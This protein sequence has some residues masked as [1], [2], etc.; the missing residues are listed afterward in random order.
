M[1]IQ[2]ILAHQITQVLQIES[3]T[4]IKMVW[5][6]KCML[7]IIIPVM[8]SNSNH[9]G[10]HSAVGKVPG[11]RCESDSRVQI[12]GSQVRSRPGPMLSWR[13]VMK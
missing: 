5:Y 6:I 8:Y 11:N 3:P 1:I 13:L 9:T 2:Y 12:Q 7:S 10:P 4:L